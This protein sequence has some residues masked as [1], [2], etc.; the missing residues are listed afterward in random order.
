MNSKTIQLPREVH[1][2]PNIIN[3]IGKI[4]TDLRFYDDALI[5]CGNTT[6]KIAGRQVIDSLNDANFS[7]DHIKV[8]SATQDSVDKV[9]KL[10]SN[11]TIVL[12]VGGG[13]I[14]DVAKLAAT[15]KETYFLSVP[16]TASHDGIT[17]PLASIKNNQ[18][19]VSVKAQSPIAVIA[20]TEIINN[21]PYRFLAAGCGDVISN[22]TAVLDWKLAKRLQNEEYSESAASLAKMTAQLITDGADNIKP[23]LEASVRLVAKALFSTGVAISIAN[24]SRPASGSEHLFS[25][26]LDKIAKH[27]A[28]HGEQCGVGSILMMSLHGGNWKFIQKSLKKVK[29]PTT[30]KELKIKEEEIIEALTT[31]HTIRNR[32][33]ILGDR[34]LS[35]EAAE[36]LAI[37]TGV[38][39]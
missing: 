22:Y 1:I 14:I 9:K 3:N 11:K 20:D 29:A 39:T 32:Y 6:Y 33:T 38:I 30:A 23:G 8:D 26:A 36:E 19:S 25:H 18:G 10:I 16:T 31:A 24:S 13:K 35:R 12:G 5:V 17:S 7:T 4:C 2:G 27:P 21:A 28:L 34:G 15:D 37:K